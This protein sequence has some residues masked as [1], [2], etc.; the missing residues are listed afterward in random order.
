MVIRKIVMLVLFIALAGISIGIF[1]PRLVQAGKVV[2]KRNVI[3]RAFYKQTLNGSMSTSTNAY[4]QSLGGVD[5]YNN[6]QT[7][8][9]DSYSASWTTC[10]AG[11][12]WCGTGDSAYADVKDTSTGL[13]WSIRLG[14]GAS[15]NWFVANNCEDP[16][17]G[18]DGVCDAN[19]EI[20]CQCVKKTSSKTGCESLGG[21][22]RLPHQKELMQVYI[23]GSWGNLSNPGYYFW[24]ATTRSLSTQQAWYVYLGYGY[25]SYN[26]KTYGA[27]YRVRCVRP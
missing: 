22:W 14:G 26:G 13:V 23:D 24:S 25:T 8:P 6:N 15:Y 16:G 21:G 17:P 20:A 9:T 11:N 7:M 5:D 10:A 18:G 2:F 19:G 3:V 27:D 1:S 4:P 12:N